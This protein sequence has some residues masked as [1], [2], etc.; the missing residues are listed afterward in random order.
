MR[1]TLTELLYRRYSELYAEHTLPASESAMSWGFQ[2]DDGWFAIIDCLSSVFCR[3]V[4][5]LCVTSVK[6]KI[7]VLRVNTDTLGDY[8]QGAIAVASAFSQVRCERSGHAGIL[9]IRG[10][11]TIQ[12]LAPDL[13]PDFSPLAPLTELGSPPPVGT[14]VW[15]MAALATRHTAFPLLAVTSPSPAYR[16]L[17]HACLSSVTRKA[18]PNATIPPIH[19]IADDAAGGILLE[20]GSDPSNPFFDGAVA[21]TLAMARRLDRRTGACGPVNDLG[22]LTA[23]D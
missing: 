16:D 4:T 13:D 10:G 20:Y 17:L 1:Q 18:E 9:M 8:T 22:E 14:G 2:H 21:F 5:P 6:Q 12:T 15:S 3:S 7:G 11:R 19:R 23:G